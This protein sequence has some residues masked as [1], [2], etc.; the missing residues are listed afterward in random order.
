MTRVSGEK[1]ARMSELAVPSLDGSSAYD[2]G[3]L[4]HRFRPAVSELASRPNPACS[5]FVDGDELRMVFTFLKGGKIH[6]RMH[7]HRIVQQKLHLA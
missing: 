1:A 5:L 7:T 3:S 6:T 4:T 2:H